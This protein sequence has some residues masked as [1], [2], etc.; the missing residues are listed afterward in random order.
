MGRLQ[1][2][3]QA[4]DKLLS[5]FKDAPTKCTE[6]SHKMTEATRLLQEMPGQ[7]P[8]LPAPGADQKAKYTS[9]WTFRSVML[10]RMRQAGVKELKVDSIGLQPY[11]CMNPD[12]CLH[13]QRVFQANRAT[14]RTTIAASGVQSCCPWRCASLATGALIRS[15]LRTSMFNGGNK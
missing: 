3:I 1:R 14:I 12:E 6:W 9:M 8:R 10:F 5:T 2:L 13:I 15:T 7:V 4:W 11:L